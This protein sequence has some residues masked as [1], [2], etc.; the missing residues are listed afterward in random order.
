MA[1]IVIKT[2]DKQF[3]LAFNRNSIV[4]M[5]EDGFNVKDIETKPLSTIVKLIRGAFYMYQPD[6]TDDEIDAIVDEIDSS[7]EFVKALV[8]M[9]SNALSALTIGNQD[10]TK[11][12]KWEKH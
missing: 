1:S 9:Y 10:K 8:E 12:F 5:E 7:D 4:R 6:M 2:N 3:K 11:N